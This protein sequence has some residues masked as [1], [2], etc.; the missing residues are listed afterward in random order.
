MA[1]T[2]T[3]EM[4]AT[5]RDVCARIVKSGHGILAADESTGMLTYQLICLLHTSQCS[6]L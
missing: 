1:T 2:L 5:M 3:D 4:K 6:S